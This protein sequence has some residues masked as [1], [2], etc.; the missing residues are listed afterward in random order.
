MFKSMHYSKRFQKIS[1]FPGRILNMRLETLAPCLSHPFFHT[2]SM[3][4]EVL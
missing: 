3:L 2:H 1:H 4:K